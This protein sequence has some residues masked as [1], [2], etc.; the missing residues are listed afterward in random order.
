MSFVKTSWLMLFR[1]LIDIYC[2]SHT[3]HV[4]TA[5]GENTEPLNFTAGHTCGYYFASKWLN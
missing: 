4:N 1:E 2:E 3:K 5:C